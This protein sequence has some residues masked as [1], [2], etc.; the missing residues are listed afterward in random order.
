MDETSVR[1][2]QTGRIGLVAGAPWKTLRGPRPIAQ[3]VTKGQQR[4]A[5]THV[6]LLCDNA[7]VQGVL[8]QLLLAGSGSMTQAQAEAV[9][10]ALRGPLELHVLK[11]GWVNTDV[12]CY[13]AGRIRASLPPADAGRHIILTMDVYKAHLSKQAL[14][15]FGRAR[16]AVHFVPA[17]ATWIM[18]PCDT[19]LFASYKRCLAKVCQEN[20]LRGSNSTCS[21]EALA[22]GISVVVNEFM[23]QRDWAH[24]F[25]HTG[26]VGHQEQVSDRLS[27]KLGGVLPHGGPS[28]MPS[29]TSLL[30]LFPQRVTVDVED[31]FA[32][33]LPGKRKGGGHRAQGGRCHEEERSTE[34]GV[35]TGRLRSS[36]R[37]KLDPAPAPDPDSCP[38]PPLP[39]PAVAPSAAPQPPTL[40]VGRRISR[41][42]RRWL[43]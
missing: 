21:W 22:H 32:C 11:K 2:Y 36:S 31:L 20:M 3:A 38:P 27:A 10:R 13:L 29:L 41:L 19:H 28:A 5:L 34:H 6:A 40:P 42:P 24:A 7:S 23:P 43:K 8:P 18:Q 15:E 33:F 25:A 39:P 30:E 4:A 9:R 16:I 1:M 35:W 37:L 14:Q 17:K 26:L 12:M